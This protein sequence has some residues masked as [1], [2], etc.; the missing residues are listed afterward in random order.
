M[1]EKLTVISVLAFVLVL[2][3]VVTIL[4][5]WK[6]SEFSF[7]SFNL[8][9]KKHSSSTEREKSEFAINSDEEI[10]MIQLP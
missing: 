4:I 5:R 9:K 6:F 1:G 2:S 8:P 3:H 10:K 7:L